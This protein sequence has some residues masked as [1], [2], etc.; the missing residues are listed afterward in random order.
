MERFYYANQ[1]EMLHCGSLPDL[2]PR[3]QRNRQGD[4]QPSCTKYRV[5]SCH[6]SQHSE[7]FE[8]GRS[9][10]H[11]P[12]NRRCGIVSRSIPNHAVS[13]LYRAGAGWHEFYHW[14]SPMPGSPL[15]SGTKHWQSLTSSLPQD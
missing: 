10:Y 9:D 1:H 12:W 6:Y 3:S 15:P 4:Q 2:H 5:Q 14:N 7:R 13:D 8:K 11:P